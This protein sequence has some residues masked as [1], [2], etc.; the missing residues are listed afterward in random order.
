MSNDRWKKKEAGR[1]SQRSSG[2]MKKETYVGVWD[3]GYR[4]RGQAKLSYPRALCKLANVVNDIWENWL[5]WCTRLMHT[6][7]TL[8]Y[9]D[10]HHNHNHN[11]INIG[12]T[13]IN[14]IHL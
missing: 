4:G 1:G 9:P 6:Y 12:V 11:K 14:L 7:V 10:L 2:G 13:L 5:M 3:A 8:S